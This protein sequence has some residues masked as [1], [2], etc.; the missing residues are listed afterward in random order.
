M[1]PTAELG[2]AFPKGQGGPRRAYHKPGGGM[3]AKE[4]SD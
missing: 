3:R 1:K 4:K 2:E